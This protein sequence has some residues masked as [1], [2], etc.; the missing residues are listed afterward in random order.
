MPNAWVDHVK[1]FAKRKGITY[2]CAMSDTECKAEY[3][4]KKPTKTSKSA[5]GGSEKKK[6]DI[7]KKILKELDRREGRAGNDTDP[8]GSVKDL[9]INPEREGKTKKQIVDSAYDYFQT[10]TN[11][12]S[13]IKKSVLMR[14]LFMELKDLMD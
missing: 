9:L 6:Y 2:G 4:A 7:V 12:Y 5:G 11:I 3:N 8:F 14:K 13:D 1:E 10:H